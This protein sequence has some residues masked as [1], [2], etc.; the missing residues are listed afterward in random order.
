MSLQVGTGLCPPVKYPRDVQQRP[1]TTYR[2]WWCVYLREPQLHTPVCFDLRLGHCVVLACKPLW[3][4]KKKKTNW[5][6]CLSA[7][8]DIPSRQ[9]VL[10]PSPLK[11]FS[12]IWFFF[13]LESR[14]C[15][16][17][18]TNCPLK[19]QCNKKTALLDREGS[20]FDTLV[21]SLRT[22]A[23][24]SKLNE[25]AVNYCWKYHNHEA[26]VLSHSLLN[27][28]HKTQDE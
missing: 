23:I 20:V 15:L 28:H 12:S 21:I 1:R 7:R 4:R 11:W 18:H 16:V 5:I 24:N 27:N 17:S 19:G 9:A 10:K 3:K 14:N 6:V 2:G 13:A 22:T 25:T 26:E 8:V